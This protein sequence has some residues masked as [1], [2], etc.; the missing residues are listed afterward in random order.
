MEKT[1]NTRNE[2]KRP[3]KPSSKK[4]GQLKELESKILDLKEI[5]HEVNPYEPLPLSIQQK[6]ENCGI[7]ATLDPFR[8]TNTLL[9]TMEDAIEKRGRLRSELGLDPDAPLEDSTSPNVK[10]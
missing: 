9:L 1:S 5:S 10:H 7:P 3:S 4:Q 6:L 8:L 2:S